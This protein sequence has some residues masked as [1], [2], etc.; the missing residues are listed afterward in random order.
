MQEGLSKEKDLALLEDDR[1]YEPT[2]EDDIEHIERGIEEY[3][4]WCE[5]AKR[6]HRESKRLEEQLSENLEV[7]GIAYDK[8]PSGVQKANVT[9]FVHELILKQATAEKECQNAHKRAEYI[10]NEYRLKE[11]FDSLTIEETDLIHARYWLRL[12]YEEIARA[13]MYND[14]SYV[15]RKIRRILKKMARTISEAE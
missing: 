4:Y 14:K 9:T 3:I 11:A 8:E 5:A 6:L 10:Y 13:S 12:K 15:H 2:E 1:I 7:R